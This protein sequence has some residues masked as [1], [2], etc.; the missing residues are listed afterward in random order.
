VRYNAAIVKRLFRI[1][2]NAATLGSPVLWLA[3]ARGLSAIR[4]PRSGR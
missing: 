1:L 2:L 3:D 4:H